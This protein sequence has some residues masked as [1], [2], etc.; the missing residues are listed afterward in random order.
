VQQ[1]SLQ[2]ECSDSEAVIASGFKVWCPYSLIQLLV[3][4]VNMLFLTFGMLLNQK[5]EI[6][7]QS[8][9]ETNFKVDVEPT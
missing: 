3:I 5:M 1:K 9:K 8:R 2:N 7:G 4:V 6:N